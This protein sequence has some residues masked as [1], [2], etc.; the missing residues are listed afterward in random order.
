MAAALKRYIHAEACLEHSLCHGGARVN[1][2]EQGVGQALHLV[3]GV[4]CQG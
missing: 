2:R 3:S 1:Q 4:A